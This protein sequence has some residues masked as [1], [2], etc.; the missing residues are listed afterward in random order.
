LSTLGDNTIAEFYQEHGLT[1]SVLGKN[2]FPVKSA[3]LA[4]LTG[5]DC[6]ANAE[7]VRRILLGEE[8]GAKREAVLFNAAAALFVAGSS[9]S[10]FDGWEMAATVIDSGQASQKLAELSR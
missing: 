8:R 2:S 10:L 4:D 3:T 7:I 9:R 5:S 1:V 6:E